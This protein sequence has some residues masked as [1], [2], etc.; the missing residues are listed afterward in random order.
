VA[1]GAKEEVRRIVLTGATRGLGRAL[2]AGFIA[3]GHRVYGCGTSARLTEELGR[4]YRGKGE[5]RVVDVADE[6]A[7]LAWA[8]EVL[9]GG[10]PDLLINNA[11]VGNSPA[12]LWE[13]PAREFSRLI[14]VNVKGMFHVLRAFVPSMAAR[15][16]GV[17]VNLSSG[18]GRRADAQAGPYCASKFAVEGMTQ[19]LAAELPRGMA[20]VPLS[21][22]VIDTEMLRGF[23]GG[24]AGGYPSPQDWARSAVPYILSLGPEHNGQSLSVP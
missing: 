1:R 20:A 8:A 15:G 2:T 16:R 3:A 5:F 18:W 17:V 19:S 22:G 7:V 23:F 9:A 10:P 4:L 6:P 13:V 12:R 21:P 24:E 11:A 14:D